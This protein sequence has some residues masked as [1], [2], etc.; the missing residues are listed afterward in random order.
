MTLAPVELIHYDGV[1]YKIPVDAEHQA[2]EI[3]RTL[4]KKIKDIQV[5]KIFFVLLMIM[6]SMEL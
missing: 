1:D 6:N 2:G 3:T 4:S 5:F